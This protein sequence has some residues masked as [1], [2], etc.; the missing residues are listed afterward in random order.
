M[1]P[2]TRPQLSLEQAYIPNGVTCQK[3]K[4][5]DCTILR[6]MYVLH[7]RL[8]ATEVYALL[9]DVQRHLLVFWLNLNGTCVNDPR[10][11]T[12]LVA[13]ME[14]SET[15]CSW[16]FGTVDFSHDQVTQILQCVQRN[17]VITQVQVHNW[18]SPHA[19]SL[20]SH[21]SA[22]RKKSFKISNRLLVNTTWTGNQSI[23]SQKLF[24]SE[25]NFTRTLAALF[26]CKDGDDGATKLDALKQTQIDDATEMLMCITRRT[27][28]TIRGRMSGVL[29]EVA[30]EFIPFIPAGIKTKRELAK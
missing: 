7:E 14:H 8:N 6:A 23:L 15:I 10:V 28:P 11:F 5:S 24:L 16:S 2:T 26:G 18:T 12:Q 1:A 4:G 27:T 19:K 17:P 3:L 13:L 29:R 30:T 21:M 9:R 22:N 20:D 25:P